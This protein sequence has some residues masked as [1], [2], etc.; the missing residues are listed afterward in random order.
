MSH[1]WIQPVDAT[2]FAEVIVPY[3]CRL[4]V[5]RGTEMRE[6]HKVMGHGSLHQC[7]RFLDEQ[8]VGIPRLV[9]AENSMAAA[10][11]VAAGGRALDVVRTET[12]GRLVGLVEVCLRHR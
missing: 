2:T 4:M 3:S 1:A 11:E 7:S 5:K 9:H 10:H 12:A 8:L 6:I